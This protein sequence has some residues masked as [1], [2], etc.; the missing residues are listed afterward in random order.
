MNAG[1]DKKKKKKKKN[2][3]K[4]CDLMHKVNAYLK[5]H[6]QISL[7]QPVNCFGALECHD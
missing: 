7:S 3:G 6:F 1:K 5:A 2:L 4:M